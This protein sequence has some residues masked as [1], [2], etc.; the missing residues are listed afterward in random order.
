[1]KQASAAVRWWQSFSAEELESLRRPETA[2]EVE[3][4]REPG[5]GN[6]RRPPAIL[7]FS[8]LGELDT[9]ELELR[10]SKTES[11]HILLFSSCMFDVSLKS[12]TWAMNASVFKLT[13]APFI[14]L[15][16]ES[17]IMIWLRIIWCITNH[18][19]CRW[20]QTIQIKL[21]YVG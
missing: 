10:R 11:C 6:F 8:M 18:W 12:A 17:L 1:M 5:S 19:W 2:S 14:F 21:K 9:F 3:L 4:R 13:A 15:G 20:E 7:L 16:D